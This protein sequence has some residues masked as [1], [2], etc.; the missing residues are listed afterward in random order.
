MSTKLRA[1]TLE[2]NKAILEY[3]SY[4][5]SGWKAAIRI[6][7]NTANPLTDRESLVYALRNSHG[8]RWLQSFRMEDARTAV[9]KATWSGNTHATWN[10]PAAR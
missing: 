7:W 3:G 6:L 8:P 10:Q 1:L 9:F 4:Y 5:E 2:E